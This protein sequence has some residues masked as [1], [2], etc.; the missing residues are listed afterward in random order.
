MEDINTREKKKMKAPTTLSSTLFKSIL[1]HSYLRSLIFNHVSSIHKQL[2]ITTVKVSSLNT[3]NDYIRYGLNDLFFKHIDQLWSLMFPDDY[4]NDNKITKIMTTAIDYHNDRVLEYLLNRIKRE[5]GPFQT[6]VTVNYEKKRAS[7][8]VKLLSANVFN[9]LVDD[10][11]QIESD[12]LLHRMAK[13]AIMVVGDVD[14]IRHLFNRYNLVDNLSSLF[15]EYQQAGCASPTAMKELFEK[16]TDLELIELY[17]AVIKVNKNDGTRS[18]TENILNALANDRIKLVQNILNVSSRRDNHMSDWKRSVSWQLFSPYATK[19]TSENV[20]KNELNHFSLSWDRYDYDDQGLLEKFK[21]GTD[22]DMLEF[23]VSRQNSNSAAFK[24]FINQKWPFPLSLASASSKEAVSFLLEYA[25]KD[26]TFVINV[27][28]NYPYHPIK[29]IDPIFCSR[30]YID[31]FSKYVVFRYSTS[32]STSNIVRSTLRQAPKGQEYEELDYVLKSKFCHN[33]NIDFA[34]SLASIIDLSSDDG[35][36]HFIERLVAYANEYPTKCLFPMESVHKYTQDDYHGRDQF[37]SVV[38]R[39]LDECGIDETDDEPI[40]ITG[41]SDKWILPPLLVET[42]AD[43]LSV[44]HYYFYLSSAAMTT[45][46]ELYKKMFKL[47]S[48]GNKV[49]SFDLVRIVSLLVNAG[50]YAFT[51][52]FIINSYIDLTAEKPKTLKK[53][54]DIIFQ[55]YFDLVKKGTL[56][57]E[58]DGMD[59]DQQD[60]QELAEEILNLLP[61][62]NQFEILYYAMDMTDDQ[63]NNIWDQFYND[64]NVGDWLVDPSKH[65]ESLKYNQKF[66]NHLERLYRLYQQDQLDRHQTIKYPMNPPPLIIEYIGIWNQCIQNYYFNNKDNNSNNNRIVTNYTQKEYDHFMK[67]AIEIGFIPDKELK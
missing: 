51:K 1:N 61:T 56:A 38:A 60:Y 21:N 42:M 26:G 10:N 23:M 37:L 50:H 46:M 43:Q 67:L 41:E 49:D 3:A 2:D 35:N 45:N 62:E 28:T 17:R 14:V 36:E 7:H 48:E 12:G 53:S 25:Q 6:M 9:L 15:T 64:S 13:T 66:F 39:V 47:C 11:V 27:G 63:F 57:K 34:D 8:I 59:I 20:R 31:L 33:L 58:D 52:E 29:E 40:F 4:R 44:Y 19:K 32:S 65:L 54:M 24:E 5:S 55:L 16:K 22:I 30:H 18:Q